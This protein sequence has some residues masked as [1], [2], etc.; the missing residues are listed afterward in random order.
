MVASYLQKLNNQTYRIKT[1]NQNDLQMAELQKKSEEENKKANEWLNQFRPNYE[2]T[3]ARIE[4]HQER[5]LFSLEIILLVLIGAFFVNLLSTTLYD[6]SLSL[7][8]QASIEKLTLD[9]IMTVGS[10]LALMAI[11]FLFKRQLMKYLPQRPVLTLTVKPEDTKPFLNEER[12]N[13]ITEFM[14]EGKLT[15]V[16]SF[17]D[18]VFKFLERDSVF[19]FGKELDEPIKQYEEKETI[20]PNDD[21][22]K[23]LVTIAKDYDI[24]FV[25]LTGV[26]ITLQIKLMPDVVYSF[27]EKGDMTASYSF[28]LTFYLMILNPE[29]CD[30]N[31]LLEWYYLHR[32]KDVVKFASHAIN[33][34]FRAAGLEYSFEKRKPKQE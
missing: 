13:D 19:L 2:S 9:S 27:G 3:L 11:F 1:S 10:L 33:W 30:A 34:S 15:N 12:F 18:S 32:A 5:K 24:S 16:K 31:K 14:K 7:T 26:K 17:A 20:I 4:K 25:S 29:H 22:H 23:D 21:S 28:Y 8:A 6:L